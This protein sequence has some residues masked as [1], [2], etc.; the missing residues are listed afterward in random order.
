MTNIPVRLFLAQYHFFLTVIGNTGILQQRK[1]EDIQCCYILKPEKMVVFWAKVV[2]MHF[3][4]TSLILGCYY[5][6]L[7]NA[8]LW[9]WSSQKSLPHSNPNSL[10][11][12]SSP[13][14]ICFLSQ[15]H[16]CFYTCVHTCV[17]A[18]PQP[19]CSCSSFRGRKNGRNWRERREWRMLQSWLEH[20]GLNVIC[21]A[22]KFNTDV[23]VKLLHRFYT[24]SWI[25][26][27]IDLE[28]SVSSN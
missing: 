14:Y 6:P 16:I 2:L 27:K 18:I 10:Q 15:P 23:S 8:V 17:C 1:A 24:I 12:F 21:C 19:S 9:I 4:S 26:G 7:A 25:F 11:S 22:Q 5:V 13:H 20:K 28:F 3:G